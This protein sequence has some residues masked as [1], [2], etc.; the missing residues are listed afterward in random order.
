MANVS[1]RQ[2][3]PRRCRVLA[4]WEK[5]VNEL[6]TA[7]QGEEISDKDLEKYQIQ[8]IHFD[9]EK[10]AG[11]SMNIGPN[12]PILFR[13]L[14]SGFFNQHPINMEELGDS[15]AQELLDFPDYPSYRS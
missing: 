8:H 12:T 3:T 11:E 2:L 4:L 10:Y 13:P 9:F 7:L 5:V 1:T 15:E 14:S 6:D